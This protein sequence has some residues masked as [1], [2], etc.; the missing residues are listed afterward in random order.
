MKRK[1]GQ[2]GAPASPPTDEP[3]ATP[4]ADEGPKVEQ[5]EQKQEKKQPKH[6]PSFAELGL[7]PRLV[8]AVAKQSFEKP[9]LVQRKA[10]PLALQGQDVLCKAKTGSGK[11]A[12]YV[13]PLLSGILKRKSTDST[14]FTAALILVPTRE[15]ADQVFKAIELFS[16]FCSKDI[17]AAKLTENVSDAVQRSLLSNVP[18]IVVSTPSRAWHSINAAGLSLEKLQYLVLDEADLVL[19]YGYDEDMENISRAL[20]KGVQTIMMSAT[21]SAELDTLKGI[22][23]RNPTLLDLNEK[24]GA[25]DEKLDQFYVKCSEDD[26]WL[27]AYLIFKLQL[28]KGKCLIFVAD[29]DR[30]YRLKLFFE[31]FS[32]R[33][34]ILN[35]E[36]PINTRI[37]M[38]DEFNK[39]MYDIIIASDEKSEIFGDETAGEEASKKQKEKAE[40][41]QP[42]KKRKTQKDQEYGVSRGIDFRNLAAVVNFDLPTSATS[43][44]HRIGRTAR[45]G[46]TGM[47]LSFVIPKELYGK[48][49]P[50]SL[51]SC[52]NDEKILAKIIRQ[53]AKQE[54]AIE[55]YNFSKKEMEAF[56]YR[57]NDALRAVT[58]VA[59]REARTKELRQ[60]LLRSETL[61]RYFEENPAELSHLR[62]DGELGRT[63]R[64]QA[65]LK[66]V[67]DYLLP[68]E[69]K[70]ALSSQEIG[71]VP[72][73]NADAKKR[74]HKRG[75]PS[76]RSFKVGGKKRDP[77]KTF[78]VRRKP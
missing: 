22:F 66:H 28:I 14:P 71:F 9:T 58:K 53:Q 63:T 21:L 30:S 73:R 44:Q 18:D 64:T 16:T 5:A 70:K 62:H 54:R 29:I 33:S 65:H 8:Q 42:S 72:F 51:R 75:K 69:G 4:Q 35:S 40:S 67:P 55:P 47:A 74:G 37:K 50:T 78:K 43:Y 10:I 31:Q 45:A 17:Q 76:G 77:L 48:H 19:S 32:I 46:R 2:S 49:K 15:L 26:K 36:L 68:K 56:R 7:D 41:D 38:I 23:C 1:L 6:D 57:M 3:V 39:G 52:E 20:P 27:I 61:K 59:V 60:E 12:A 34:C 13:L 24:M 25:E 11:T